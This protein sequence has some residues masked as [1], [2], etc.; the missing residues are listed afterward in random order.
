MGNEQCGHAR[1]VRAHTDAVTSNAGLRHFEE[2]GSD[3][4]AIAN[5]DLVIGQTFDREVFSKLTPGEVASPKLFFPVTIR[6]DLINEDGTVF[7][8]MTA[9]V[10]LPIAID[11]EATHNAPALNGTFP[12]TRMNTLALPRNVAGKAYVKRDQFRH[13]P[14]FSYKEIGLLKFVFC[15]DFLWED[16]AHHLRMTPD[17]AGLTSRV[18]S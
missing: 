17:Q 10:A 2:S 7:P 3:P 14:Q 18:R 5:A 9:Q 8:A 1:F 13:E 11:V 6:L 16:R 12:D 4:E 15:E